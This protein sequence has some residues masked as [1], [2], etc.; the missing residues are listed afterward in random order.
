MG[1]HINVDE[2]GAPEKFTGCK[3]VPIATR[4]GKL[5][6]EAA[7]AVYHGVGVEHHVQ[8]RVISITQATEVGTVYSP[9]EIRQPGRL[10]P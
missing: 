8:P 4:D 10:C 6:V 7:Q 9:D 5:T 1:A 3:L 2:C